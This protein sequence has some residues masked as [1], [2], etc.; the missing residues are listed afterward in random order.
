MSNFELVLAP[1]L[2]ACKGH[3]E[4][5]QSWCRSC[6]GSAAD[7]IERLQTDAIDN[8]GVMVALREGYTEAKRRIEELES[9]ISEFIHGENVVAP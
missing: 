3:G 2:K 5:F 8:E 9:K 6:L 7:E 4:F 1:K